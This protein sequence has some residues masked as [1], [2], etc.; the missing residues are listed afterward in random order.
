MT[1]ARNPPGGVS[2]HDTPRFAVAGVTISAQFNPNR[3]PA[4]WVIDVAAPVTPVTEA[5]LHWRAIAAVYHS[6]PGS[7]TMFHVGARRAHA[8]IPNDV[9]SDD[10]GTTPTSIVARAGAS[11]GITPSRR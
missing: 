3:P 8:S 6:N 5:T 11:P 1:P 7:V 4:V 2:S 10:S 9:V